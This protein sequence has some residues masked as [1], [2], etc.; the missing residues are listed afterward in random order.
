MLKIFEKRRIIPF[1]ITF[2]IALEIFFY[3]T[4]KGEISG[5][6][7]K[8]NLAIIYHISIF[9]LFTFFLFITIRGK[10]KVNLKIILIVL[11]ISALYALSD[12][13]HQM[14]VYGREATIKDIIFDLVGSLISI[15]SYLLINK[16]NKYFK[17]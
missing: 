7:S 2:I 13:I 15:T 4:L 6:P 16:K 11:G 10:E 1:I 12:E 3:S 17:N 9:F 5:I 8:I 14:F